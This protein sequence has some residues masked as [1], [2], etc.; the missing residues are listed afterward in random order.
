MARKIIKKKT[1]INKKE[2]STST[3]SSSVATVTSSESKSVSENEQSERESK[4]SVSSDSEAINE[5]EVKKAKKIIDEVDVTCSKDEEVI[6]SSEN[7]NSSDTASGSNN[8]ESDGELQ[9]TVF[10]KGLDYDITEDSLRSEVEKIGPTGRINVPMTYDGRRNK[11]FAYV[12]FKKIEDA[13]KLL[14]LNEQEFLG[15]KVVVDKAKPKTNHL[16]YTVYVKNLAFNTTRS[17]L[18]EYFTK[19]GKIHNLSLPIDTENEGRNRGY[20]FIEYLD[21][22]IATNVVNKRHIINDRTLFLNFGQKNEKRNEK[23]SNDRLY[24]RRDNYEDNRRSRYGSRN[25]RDNRDKRDKRDK[26]DS[27]GN[28]RFYNRND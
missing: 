16:L 1:K 10:I 28:D 14:K 11:G 21:E 13:D 12:E 15:R 26:R 5:E 4:R 6:N 18:L 8:K 20:C 3:E 25:N 9:R 17:E 19:F 24:G 22:K 2:E 7:S 23:R 27:S